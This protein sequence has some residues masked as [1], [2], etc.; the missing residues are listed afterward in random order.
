MGGNSSKEAPKPKEAKNT[1]F[2][3]PVPVEEDDY[4]K[5]KEAKNTRFSQP[6]P[7]EEDDYSKPLPYE[8][9]PK[10]LQ[11]IVDNEESLWDSVY[12][13]R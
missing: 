11:E 3:Q 1:R 4:S 7:V 12:E 9:L 10:K 2:S 6:V 5:P 8:K 13:G